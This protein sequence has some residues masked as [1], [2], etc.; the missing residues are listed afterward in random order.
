[1]RRMFSEKQI[2]KLAVDGLKEELNS[3]DGFYNEFPDY[4]SELHIDTYAFFYGNED[5]QIYCSPD[6]SLVFIFSEG[7]LEIAGE[8]ITISDP[9]NICE[10]ALDKNSS[11]IEVTSGEYISLY[12]DYGYISL[13]DEGVDITSSS[14]VTVTTAGNSRIW[15]GANSDDVVWLENVKQMT[16]KFVGATWSY[17]K[18]HSSEFECSS[19]GNV[20]TIDFKSPSNYFINIKFSEVL[21]DYPGTTDILLRFDPVIY[22]ATL[23]GYMNNLTIE[24]LSPDFTTIKAHNMAIN[25]FLNNRVFCEIKSS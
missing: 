14:G 17:I 22:G 9:D 2:E 13:S 12:T 20:V 7:T 16:T 24:E 11:S 4:D 5:T 25:A 18:N 8:T 6:E 1:M 19:S 10:I 15:I 21:I 23:V 3:E